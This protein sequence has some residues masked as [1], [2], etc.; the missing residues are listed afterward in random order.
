[1][2]DGLSINLAARNCV[3][4]Y[5]RDVPPRFSGAP[6]VIETARSHEMP[7]V[8]SQPEG[9]DIQVGFYSGAYSDWLDG[10]KHRVYVRR[11]DYVSFSSEEEAVTPSS[12][13]GGRSSGWSQRSRSNAQPRRG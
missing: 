8:I 3:W 7:D 2:R 12:H 6:A 5:P 4:V 9:A 13:C 1:M 11:F 10:E